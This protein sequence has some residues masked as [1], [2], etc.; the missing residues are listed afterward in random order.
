MESSAV[1]CV[2]REEGRKREREG[3]REERVR[4][5]GGKRERE[6]ESPSPLYTILCTCKV[7]KNLTIAWVNLSIDS[8]E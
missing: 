3:G 6:R 5:R 2:G 1:V 8:R 4:G 7:H